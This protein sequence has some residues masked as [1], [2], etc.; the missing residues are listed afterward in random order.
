MLC[1]RLDQRVFPEQH[2]KIIYFDAF[3]RAVP[4]QQKDRIVCGAFELPQRRGI[5]PVKQQAVSRLLKQHAYDA[6]PDI[7][8]AADDERLLRAH[9]ITTLTRY[10][11]GTQAACIACSIWEKGYFFSMTGEKSMLPELIVSAA[12][13]KS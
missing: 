6:A 2:V 9:S 3:V 1:Q 13:W 11:P 10:A 12:A 8:C 4:V 5:A 7:A